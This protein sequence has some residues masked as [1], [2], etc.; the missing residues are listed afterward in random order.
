[1][2]CL[3]KR[4][5]DRFQTA[6][7]LLH[8]LE[9]QATPSTGVTPTQTRP[10]PAWSEPSSRRRW[11]IP[12]LL[13]VIAVGVAAYLL[14]RGASTTTGAPVNATRTQVTFNGTAEFTSALS[15]DGQR[16]AFADRS[17]DNAYNCTYDLVV[18][19]VAGSGSARVVRGMPAI[20][21]VRWTGDGRT[22]LMGGLQPGGQV[23]YFS[24]PALGGESPRFI[25]ST[26]VRLFG[27]GDSAMIG[28]VPSP[29]RLVIR[30]TTLANPLAGDTIVFEREGL[31][32]YQWSLSPG[33][34]VGVEVL[35]Q[36]VA[37][38]RCGLAAVRR[39]R[40][41]LGPAAV[42]TESRMRCQ[43]LTTTRSPRDVGCRTTTPPS[44]ATS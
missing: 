40:F 1:M 29:G 36:K 2:R 33:T 13:G 3:A 24:V 38:R 5:A 21:E 41:H 19:D 30:A 4:P 27:T 26:A 43:L 32:S 25:S 9:A 11:A 17:C 23:A 8:L 35:R 39:C 28:N 16:V 14:T 18:Q 20:Y 15:P 34:D 31:E 12:A 6:E 44:G 42:T 10:V 7:E 22:L 37:I